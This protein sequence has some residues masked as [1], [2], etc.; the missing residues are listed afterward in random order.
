MNLNRVMEPFYGS[1]AEVFPLKSASEYADLDLTHFRMQNVAQ[2]SATPIIRD[3]WG[4]F[5]PLT[6]LA[7]VAKIPSFSGINQSLPKYYKKLGTAFGVSVEAGGRSINALTQNQRFLDI[8]GVKYVFDPR[9]DKVLV[10]DSVV[11]PVLW[12]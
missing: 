3:F 6:N 10:R 5:E 8:V 9:T 1:S 2:A 12:L 7:P 11:H 4:K